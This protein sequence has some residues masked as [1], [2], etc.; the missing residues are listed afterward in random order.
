MPEARIRETAESDTSYSDAQTATVSA[1]SHNN[2][3]T[4]ERF[5]YEDERQNED[6]IRSF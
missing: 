3:D 5:I 2:G 4:C 6:G 1:D